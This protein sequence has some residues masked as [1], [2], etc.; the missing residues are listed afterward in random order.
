VTGRGGRLDGR[1]LERVR[2]VAAEV[3]GHAGLLPGQERAVLAA[4]DGHDVL[5]VSP[6]GSGKSLVYQLLGVLLEGPTVVVSPLLALQWDQMEELNATG[7]VTAAARVSS[8]ESAG[9]RDEVLRRAG[10]GD[11]EFLFLTPEQLAKDDVRREVAAAGPSLVAVDEAH[12]VSAWGH[13]FRPDY[14]RLGE[15]LEDLGRPRVVALTATAARPVREDIAARLRLREPEQVVTGFARDN[16]ALSV[17]WCPDADRQ[18]AQVLESVEDLDAPGIVYCRTRRATEEHAAALAATGRRVRAYHAGLGRRAREDAHEDFLGGDADLM[19]ATSAFGMGIDKPDVRFVLHAQVPGSPDAYYQEVGRAGRD[20]LPA[21]GVLCYRPEDL[22]LGRFFAGGVPREADVSAVVAA[23][24]ADR[25]TLRRR[26]GIGPRALGRIL[27]LLDEVERRRDS[28]PGHGE[29]VAAV[30][31]RA[32]AYRDIE[33]SRVEMI[34]AYAETDRCRMA[35]LT[36]YFGEDVPVCGRCDNCRTGR[37]REAADR[38]ADT[39]S[40]YP[41]E[42]RVSHPEFGEGT[43]MDVEEDR[44]T[45]LFTEVGYRTL[46]LAVVQ[47]NGLLERLSGSADQ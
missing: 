44:I 9:L 14:L 16:L 6:T 7:P 20:G 24:P 31:S 25:A 29:R 15:L 2:T 35:F 34:R 23:L 37:A 4:L 19:V 32:E 30:L 42:S 39:S 47:E 17:T 33:R 3:F 5:M 21:R 12:C 40:P 46:D 8:A 27:N 43:V 11:T 1:D 45:V 41:P 38:A 10:R 28:P 18:L 22:S 26:T 36:G 13:D